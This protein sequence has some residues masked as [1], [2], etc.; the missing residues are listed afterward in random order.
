MTAQCTSMKGFAVLACWHRGCVGGLDGLGCCRRIVPGQMSA[1]QLLTAR[2]RNQ[3]IHTHIH[4]HTQTGVMN[5]EAL[6][7]KFQAKC[8]S[9]PKPSNLISES[10]IKRR[11]QHLDQGLHA[12]G[13]PPKL[14]PLLLLSGSSLKIQGICVSEVGG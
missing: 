8:A 4:T 11:C 12:G 14:V 10:L 9:V 13:V 5:C 2:A 3:Y 1:I 6:K 7:P